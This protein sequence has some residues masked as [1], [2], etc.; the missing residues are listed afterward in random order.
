MDAHKACE[1]ATRRAVQPLG[2]R[3]CERRERR[4]LD[5]HAVGGRHVVGDLDG[6]GVVGLPVNCLEL[7]NGRNNRHQLPFRPL[8]YSSG[9]LPLIICTSCR[10]WNS[11]LETFTMVLSGATSSAT[12]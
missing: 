4:L 5:H 11:A 12:C 2:A 1:V 10:A 7:L 8:A 3:G 9:R 6:G